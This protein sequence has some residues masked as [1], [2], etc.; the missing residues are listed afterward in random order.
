MVAI[1][2]VIVGDI[3]EFDRLPNGAFVGLALSSASRARSRL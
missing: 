1:V 3:V 2:A